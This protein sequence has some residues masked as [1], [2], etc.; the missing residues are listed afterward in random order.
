MNNCFE[1]SD[2]KKEQYNPGEFILKKRDF[3]EFTS[4]PRYKNDSHPMSVF[5]KFDVSGNTESEIRKTLKMENEPNLFSDNDCDSIKDEHLSSIEGD[6]DEISV[7]SE[8]NS[9]D[10]EAKIEESFYKKE[11]E[12]EYDE[13]GYSVDFII[14]DERP[15]FEIK[16]DNY[17]KPIATLSLEAKKKVEMDEK[18][19]KRNQQKKEYYWNNREKI[20]QRNQKMRSTEGWKEKSQQYYRTYRK[21]NMNNQSYHQNQRNSRSRYLSSKLNKKKQSDYHKNLYASNKEKMQL[22]KKKYRQKQKDK[23]DI[24]KKKIKAKIIENEEVEEA[25]RIKNEENQKEVI[26]RYNEKK[27]DLFAVKGGGGFEQRNEQRK[28]REEKKEEKHAEM[29]RLRVLNK[30]RKKIQKAQLEIEINQEKEEKKK[31][32]NLMGQNS[33]VQN[34]I[35][36]D[37]PT[38]KLLSEYEKSLSEDQKFEII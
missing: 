5:N 6:Y 34:Q 7:S 30:R 13:E 23:L 4:V 27:K 17:F 10:V 38:N 33:E 11:E 12:S 22:V 28:L 29:I 18:K 2:T 25:E 19:R 15:H 3:N 37:M 20:N 9:I 21:K 36:N 14:E 16:R 31:L 24:Q 32:R 35:S 26:K 8:N 1:T